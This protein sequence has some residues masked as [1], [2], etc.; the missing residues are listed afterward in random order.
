MIKTVEDDNPDNSGA[1]QPGGSA[2]GKS[3]GKQAEGE[4]SEQGAEAIGDG[5]GL[6][7]VEG[8]RPGWR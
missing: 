1:K 2:K 7:H 3:D 5:A 6:F 4:Q 8:C